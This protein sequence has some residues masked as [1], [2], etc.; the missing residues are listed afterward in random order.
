MWLDV[1]T[2]L[3]NVWESEGRDVATLNVLNKSTIQGKLILVK[4]K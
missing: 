4:A 2:K 1:I 3:I